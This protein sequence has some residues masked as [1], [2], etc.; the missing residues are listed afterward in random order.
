MT[1]P[2]QVAGAFSMT[3]TFPPS[4]P[5]GR[6]DR[7]STGVILAIVIL[8]VAVGAAIG[9]WI[10]IGQTNRALDAI[11]TQASLFEAYTSRALA[12]M[13]LATVDVHDTAEQHLSDLRL[14]ISNGIM[15]C[16]VKVRRSG[17][18]TMNP[19]RISACVERVEAENLITIVGQDGIPVSQPAC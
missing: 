13:D 4:E 7:V 18:M 15:L 1:Y 5:R 6:G 8:A 19:A 16:L 12:C 17:Q 11:E 9:S 3:K 2:I 14:S 10:R